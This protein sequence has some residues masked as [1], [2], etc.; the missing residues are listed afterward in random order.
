M[1]LAADLALTTVNATPVIASQAANLL[2]VLR[3]HPIY[4]LC[5]FP[6]P[7]PF[8][9]FPFLPFLPFLFLLSL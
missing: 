4:I 3:A 9:H 8:H 5:L 7:L 6:T 1:T 2:S